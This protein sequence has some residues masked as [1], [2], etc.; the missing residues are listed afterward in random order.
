V[1]ALP[2]LATLS[3]DDLERLLRSTEDDEDAISRRRR[4]LHERID[5][6]RGERVTR[7]RGHVE[8]GT[9]DLPSPAALERSIF[10]GT[11]EVPGETLSRDDPEPG[12]LSDEELRSA[13]LA[14]EREEDDI[15]LR[16]RILHGR[17]DILRAERERRRRGL[18][19]DPADLGPIL[20]GSPR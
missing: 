17:I 2:D 20:G 8:A 5:A 4:L 16:R 10:E 15:S 6:L 1:D 3:D 14:L 12:A 9:L 18:H 19:V 11:G 7:L 13:I